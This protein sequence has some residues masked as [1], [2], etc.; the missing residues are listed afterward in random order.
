MPQDAAAHSPVDVDAGR[1]AHSL[2]GR[3]RLDCQLA[4]SPPPHRRTAALAT[5]MPRREPSRHS[6]EISRARPS[7]R[8]T[9][10]QSHNLTRQ[11]SRHSS[12]FHVHRCLHVRIRVRIRVR[13]CIS[14]ACRYTSPK[15]TRES[16][17]SPFLIPLML[18]AAPTS[19]NPFY[20]RHVE[21]RG[22]SVLRYGRQGKGTWE[23]VR[24]GWFL[25]NGDDWKVSFRCLV[26]PHGCFRALI[27]MTSL[28]AITP[29]PVIRL[30]ADRPRP[31]Y[32]PC[33]PLIPPADPHAQATLRATLRLPALLAADEHRP[34]VCHDGS[35]APDKILALCAGRP[36]SLL[37]PNPQPLC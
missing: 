8:L 11:P 36:W 4:Q 30:D 21:S 9:L 37:V 26:F 27:R 17:G 12:P 15:T 5:Q 31:R 7:Y 35:P 22:R 28:G 16:V 20:A 24:E 18:G 25:F 14:V 3:A 10:S 29:C 23:L 2:E 1:I 32:Y 34:C 6:C 33:Y 13:F 19:P